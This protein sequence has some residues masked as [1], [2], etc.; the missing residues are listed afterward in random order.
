MAGDYEARINQKIALIQSPE[1]KSIMGVCARN[2]MY[3]KDALNNGSLDQ[4][5]SLILDAEKKMGHV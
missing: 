3:P 2:K 5:A 4:L 1:M